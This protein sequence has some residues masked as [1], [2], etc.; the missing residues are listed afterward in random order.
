MLYLLAALAD[1]V[2][3]IL[4]VA[5]IFVGAPLYLFLRAGKR[6]ATAAE[7]GER[8]P[9]LLTVFVAAVFLIWA[10]ISY[11]AGTTNA[12]ADWAN[13][14]VIAIGGVF[15]LRGSIIVFQLRGFTVFSD[16]EVPQMRDFVFSAASLGIGGLHLGAALGS[17]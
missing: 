14:L 15:V 6:M 12:Y 9:A 1:L 7:N 8:W 3:S 13:Y 2:L 11:W 4:H 5:A 16:G 17:I 10:L